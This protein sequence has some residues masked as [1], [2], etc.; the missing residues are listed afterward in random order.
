M[1]FPSHGK[2][3]PRL[4]LPFLVVN[5]IQTFINALYILFLLAMLAIMPRFW[6]RHLALSLGNGLTMKGAFPL[7]PL[8]IELPFQKQIPSEM[9]CWTLLMFGVVGLLECALCWFQSVVL[10][11]H[12][13]LIP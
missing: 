3:E 9:R 8:L 1:F 13:L 7:L 10:Q 5:G 11:A 2:R 4:Y 12:S 6:Q